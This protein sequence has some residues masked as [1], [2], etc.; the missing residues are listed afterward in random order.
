[1]NYSFTN[2]RDFKF[3]DKNN[4]MDFLQIVVIKLEN[5]KYSYLKKH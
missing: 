5:S 3:G 1:M 4:C 2:S